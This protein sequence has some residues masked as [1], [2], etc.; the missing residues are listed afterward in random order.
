MNKTKK[1]KNPDV[2]FKDFTEDWQL[3]TLGNLFEITSASRVLK[4]EWTDSGVPFFRSSDVVSDYKGAD[5]I[6]AFISLELYKKLSAISGCVKKNDILVTGG[7]SIGIPYLVKTNEPLYFKDADLLW[8]KS[9][10]KVSG[11]FLYT[12]FSTTVFRNYVNSIT[13]IGTISHYTIEQA[14]LTP[15]IIPELTEQKQI[16]S[17]F[18]NLDDLITLH[19]KKYE[20]LVILKKSMLEK[21]FPKNGADVPEIRFKGFN[22]DWKEKNLSEIT[23]YHNGKGHENQQGKS[24][25]YELINLNSISIDGGL[26]PSG[27][28]INDADITLKEND[29]VMV[30]SDVGH[31]YLL[32]R[33]AIIPENNK[34]VLNQRVALLRPDNNVNSLFLL[35]NI[36]NNQD[37]FKKQGAGMSQ[38]NLSKSSVEGFTSF[39][40]CIDEQ[41]RIG[42]YFQNI[43][44]QITLHQIELDKLNNIKKA[45]FSK[46]FVSQ[47]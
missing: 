10:N 17:F 37:Y 38:L 34:Y 39:I 14:K 11:Y 43:D 6:K 27:K 9:A 33:V 8:L 15:I 13:H 1:K 31:G 5:N 2:R 35:Y 18:Q 41:K 24:G 28:F 7:G 44:N 4:N 3:K 42:E 47:E 30:L 36:N 19:Q 40:P 16:G 45:C 46:M 22:K 20:K 26:K 29:L 21:M 32:G 12:F 25:K 23:N